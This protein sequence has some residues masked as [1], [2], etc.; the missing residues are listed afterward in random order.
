MQD[1]KPLSR[2]QKRCCSAQ[3]HSDT[4]RATIAF[5]FPLK[6]NDCPQTYFSAALKQLC[7]PAHV[8]NVKGPVLMYRLLFL[9]RSDTLSTS[10]IGTYEFTIIITAYLP[11][12]KVSVLLR[13]ATSNCL[14]YFKSLA[15][16]TMRNLSGAML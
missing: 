14:P 11:E 13:F 5:H 3:S 8:K 9:L 7:P 15:C 12:P 4:S 1:F 6:G 2:R 16:L 10:L